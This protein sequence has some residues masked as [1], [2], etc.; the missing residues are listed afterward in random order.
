MS[1]RAIVLAAGKGTRMKSA[2]PK[3]LHEL[4]GRPL[5]WYVVRSLRAAGIG[6]ILVVASPDLD[7]MLGEFGVRSV[8]QPEPLGTGHA[9]AVALQALDER[10]GGRVVVAYGDMPLVRDEIFR[11]AIASLQEEGGSAL[12]VVT[13]RMPF[14]S[15][16][17]RVIRGAGGVER[18]VEVRDATPEELA[19]D[20]LNA[21]IYAFDEGALR[22]AVSSLRPDNA[23][24]EYYLTD[25]IGHVVRSGRRVVPVEA[26]DYRHVLGINDRV[27]LA[28]AR[29]EMNERICARHMRDGVTIVDPNTTYLEPELSI[30]RDTVI[31]PNTTIGRLSEIGERCTIGPNARL[32]NARLGDGVTVRES[33]VSD[34]KIGDGA[35]VGPFAHVRGDATLG[36]GVRIGNFVEVKSSQLERDV[37]VAHLSYLGDACVGERANIGAGT[38]TCNYDG[39]VK[40]RTTIGKDAFIGSNSSLVAP[41]TIGEGAL[42]G[43]S[44]V[45]TK[46]VPA[47]GRVAGNPAK[48]LPPKR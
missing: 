26:G 42:T 22:E 18:I 48:P 35:S 36:A 7:G 44:S 40:N 23:Q 32:S 43:A 25:T 9:V 5:L 4:C 8:V 3:I 2:R 46:D 20:E 10:P 47:G 38:I 27:E 12:A 6:E 17:G 33:V 34:A 41:V 11:S 1:V 19:V 37:K 28:R 15:N 30:G 14:A 24:G 31:Y 39:R 16:F 29:A 21:G 13:A 45:V